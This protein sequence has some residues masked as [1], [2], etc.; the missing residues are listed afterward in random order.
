MTELTLVSSY[1]YPLQSLIESA[2]ANQLRLLQAGLQR[3]QQRLKLFET[4]YK[5]STSIF[6]TQLEND[7]LEETLDFIEWLGEYNMLKRLEQKI[8]VLQGIQIAN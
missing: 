1:Q 4:K 6:I 2:L 5:L 3:T 8:G 7:D